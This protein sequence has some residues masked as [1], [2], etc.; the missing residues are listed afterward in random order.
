MHQ[1]QR[2]V[3]ILEH[4]DGVGDHD[5]VERS[6]DRS[7]RRRIFHV[8]QDKIEIGMQLVG[9]GDGPGAEI[10]ADPVGRLQRREQIA[11]AAAQF[12]HPLARWNQEPHELAVVFVIGGI[13]LA[14]AIQLVAVGLEVVE[15]IPLPLTGKL[16]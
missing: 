13:E 1:S 11:A 14:P 4:A 8:T 10:D 3:D 7:Q 12:Q 16:Q 6:L 5:V 2:A 9:P 15:Q